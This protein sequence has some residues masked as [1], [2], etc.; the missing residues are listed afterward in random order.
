MGCMLAKVPIDACS[1]SRVA[2]IEPSMQIEANKISA[3][4]S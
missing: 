3:M 1:R 4:A 2:A